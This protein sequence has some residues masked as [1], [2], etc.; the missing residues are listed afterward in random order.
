MGKH[1][2]RAAPPSSWTQGTPA[3]KP[4][5]Q[6]ARHLRLGQED[7][8]EAVLAAPFSFTWKFFSDRV[9]FLL[10][11]RYLREYAYFEEAV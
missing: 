10:L 4:T 5:E 8:Q 11:S 2:G 1:L 6:P 9:L 7:R 3:C